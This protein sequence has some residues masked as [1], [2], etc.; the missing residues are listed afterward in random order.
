MCRKDIGSAVNNKEGSVLQKM[1]LF[2]SKK[3]KMEE[4]YYNKLNIPELLKEDFELEIDDVFTI[5]ASGTVVT[6]QVKTGMCRLGDEAELYKADGTVLKGIIRGIDK[7][8][9]ERKPN[10]AV[11]K[12]ERVGLHIRGIEKEQ[13]N[14]G[15]RLVVKN[16][17]KYSM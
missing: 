2:K 11:Y 6:G 14:Q 12:T 17:N 1:G 4:E 15:D 8:T 3:K 16:A 9:K 10:G 5:V 7:S 13:V